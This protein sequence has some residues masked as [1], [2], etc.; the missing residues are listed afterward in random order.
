MALTDTL[1]AKQQHAVTAQLGPYLAA[2]EPSEGLPPHSGLTES[3]QVWTVSLGDFL[4]GGAAR[5]VWSHLWHHQLRPPGG[6]A[7]GFVR[8]LDQGGDAMEVRTVLLSP[9]ASQIDRALADLDHDPQFQDDAIR[10]RLLEIPDLYLKTIWLAGPGG[11]NRF[12]PLDRFAGH[13]E[14][15]LQPM[16]EEELK[17]S[18]P[19]RPVVGI[20][21]SASPA[22]TPR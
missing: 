5:A 1:D 10:V 18:L 14:L 2:F 7:A 21:G 22:A 17:A 8:S 15:Q 13:G 12:V 16:S 11:T 9:I 3:L 20:S 19:A 6:P 4:A